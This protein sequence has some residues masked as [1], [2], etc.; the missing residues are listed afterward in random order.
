MAAPPGRRRTT[1]T[2]NLEWK[3]E[4]AGS[5]PGDRFIRI[6]THRNFIRTSAGH[7]VPRPNIDQPATPLGRALK[8]TGHL[9][10]GNPLMSSQEMEERLG[11][12]KALAV[13]SSDNLSS[14]AYATEEIM[15]VVVL[16]GL[17]ALNLTLPL[18]VAIVFLL[19]IVVTSYRQT[20]RA[21]PSGG[22]SYI[23]ASDNLGELPGLTA[24]VALLIDYVLTVAVSV[25]A[26]VAAI[27]SWAPHLL[28]HTVP[29]AIVAVVLIAWANL[30][31]MREAGTLFA[32]PTYGFIV[33]MYGLIGFGLFRLMTGGASYAPP[34][35]ALVPGGE[36][37]T[38]FLVLSA[39][40]QGCTA[41]TG[42]EAV[43][44]G[45]LVFKAPESRNARATIVW[46]GVLLGSMFLGLSYLATQLN[47]LPADQE[48]VLSQIGRSIFGDG[49][50]WTLLQFATMSILILA[51]NTS[52]AD[53]PRLASILARD[54]FL[55]RAFRFRGDRLAFN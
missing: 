28:P 44:N 35:T 43:S 55:P 18:S 3:E 52:F 16:G 45:V 36:P 5:K 38:L 26:G 1:G 23:V 32:I 29:L 19:A 10:W 9:L 27:T 15:K 53:F 51:A 21:Y 31:G 12:V 6:G 48:T 17:A 2:P 13:L 11:K 54:G 50:L 7:I 34:E 4:I 46:I 39:F 24:G 20:I 37:V 41:M 47:I 49:P 40:A 14:V 25:A 30:R 22:G 33:L 42:T 8:R